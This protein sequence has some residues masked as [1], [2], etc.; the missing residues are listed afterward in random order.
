MLVELQTN[1]GRVTAE[2]N[3][4]DSVPSLMCAPN[5]KWIS[6]LNFTFVRRHYET[7]PQ[8]LLYR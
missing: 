3:E 2:Q 5:R 8:L 4:I 7:I 1:Q 6:R